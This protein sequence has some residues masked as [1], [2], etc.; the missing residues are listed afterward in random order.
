MSLPGVRARIPLGAGLSEIYRVSPPSILQ[1]YFDVVSLE[2]HFAL[3]C[4][5]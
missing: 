1:H 3:T 4:F 2:R 5:T